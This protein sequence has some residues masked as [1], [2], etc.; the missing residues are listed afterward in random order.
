MTGNC[1]VSCKPCR[2]GSIT[3]ARSFLKR[4]GRGQSVFVIRSGGVELIRHTSS[5]KTKV[6]AHLGSGQIFGEMALVDRQPR[7]AT[8]RVAEDGEIYLLD[9][10]ALESLV[11]R[12]AEIGVDIMRNI[13]IVLSALL[14]KANEELDKGH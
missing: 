8:A 9:A 10:T 12:D 11:R 6:L 7:T 2:S 14:R 1:A 13:A 4:D 3:K 5:E